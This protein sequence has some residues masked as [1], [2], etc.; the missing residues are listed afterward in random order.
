MFKV[1]LI[2]IPIKNFQAASAL[3]LLWIPQALKGIGTACGGGRLG[4]RLLFEEYKYQ[5]KD[6][7]YGTYKALTSQDDV[8]QGRVLK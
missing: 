5:P 3:P 2:A 8:I 7:M 4:L 6:R 1:G